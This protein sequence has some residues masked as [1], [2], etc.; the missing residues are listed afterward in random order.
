[1]LVLEEALW[2]VGVVWLVL[3]LLLVAWQERPVEVLRLVEWWEVGAQLNCFWL[4]LRLREEAPAPLVSGSEQSV[5]SPV[6]AAVPP[7]A[8]GLVRQR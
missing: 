5:M 6:V 1:M 7:S 4:W 3:V 2:Q 8:H